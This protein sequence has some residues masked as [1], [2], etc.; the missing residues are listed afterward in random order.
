MR[1][2]SL[3]LLFLGAGCSSPPPYPAYAIEGN[4]E[5]IAQVVVADRTL[6]DVVRAG[7]PLVERMVPDDNLRVVVPIQNTDL[8]SIQVL[9]QFAFFDAQRRPLPDETNRQVM[10][11][12]PGSISNFQAI[13][14]SRRAA[15]FV[16]RLSWNK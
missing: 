8:E 15:D 5:Q 7:A 1:T 10:T 9:A 4:A 6:R 13:S 12:P 2:V 3:T 11:L 16:L 14:R